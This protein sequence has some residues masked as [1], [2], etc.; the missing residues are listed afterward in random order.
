[1]RACGHAEPGMITMACA[2]RVWAY[3][4]CDIYYTDPVLREETLVHE[5]KHCKGYDHP[6]AH[7]IPQIQ[8]NIR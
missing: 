5:R 2:V 6:V 8:F 4:R 1:M 3:Q 7:A